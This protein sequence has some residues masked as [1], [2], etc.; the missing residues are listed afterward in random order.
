MSFESFKINRNSKR[1]LNH[2]IKIVSVLKEI[3]TI[4]LEKNQETSINPGGIIFTLVYLSSCWKPLYFN[5]IQVKRFF[6]DDTIIQRY[7]VVSEG[8]AQTG[9][10]LKISENI[11]GMVLKDVTKRC[12]D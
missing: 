3:Q 2:N 4:S 10:M 12:I 7:L 8:E 1:L 6:C 9:T 5:T 11:Y